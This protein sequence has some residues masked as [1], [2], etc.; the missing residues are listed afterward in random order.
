MA[1]VETEKFSHAVNPA[2]GSWRQE[3]VKLRKTSRPPVLSPTPE[4]ETP[5]S[6]SAELVFVG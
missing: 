4:N 3:N 5:L 1:H 2:L 6:F